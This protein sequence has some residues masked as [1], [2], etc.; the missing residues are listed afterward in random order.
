M[1]VICPRPV[2]YSGNKFSDVS[3]N[4]RTDAVFCSVAAWCQN[5]RYLA[6]ATGSEEMSRQLFIGY[7]AVA[8]LRKNTRTLYEFDIG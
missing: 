3:S 6:T 4:V 1:L 8:K 2:C 5:R 7:V